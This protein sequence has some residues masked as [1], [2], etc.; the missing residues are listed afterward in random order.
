MKNI[1]TIAILGAQFFK[2]PSSR[3]KVESPTIFEAYTSLEDAID[4]MDEEIESVLHEIQFLGN[5]I[6][7]TDACIDTVYNDIWFAV[8][9]RTTCNQIF[10]HRYFITI[11]NLVVK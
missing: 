2:L 1:K 8:K 4:S 5:T 6:L 11:N 9:Y 10:M 7:Y 3:F